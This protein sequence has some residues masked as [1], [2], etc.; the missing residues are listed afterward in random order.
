PELYRLED[1]AAEQ[2]GVLRAVIDVIGRQLAVARRSVDRLGEDPFIE[3]ADDWAVAY[4]ADLVGTRLVHEL[5]RRAR[6]IDVARTIF[7]RRR[8]GTPRVLEM[9]VRD[10]AGWEGALVESFRRLARARHRLDPEPAP[11]AG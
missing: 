9:L 1:G 11:L 4:L 5:N 2:P 8:K 7:Y 6:R 10:I 3:T